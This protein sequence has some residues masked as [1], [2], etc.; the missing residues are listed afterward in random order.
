MRKTL[1]GALLIAVFAAAANTTEQ[2]EITSDRFEADEG[3][4]ISKFI[5]H[6]H[7]VKGPDELNASK[8]IVY[9]DAKRNPKRYEAI[10]NASFIVHMQKNDEYYTG[11]ADKLVYKPVKQIYEFY[12]H[13]VL[14]QPKLDRTVKGDEVIVDRLTGKSTVKGNKHKPVKFIFQVEEKRGKNR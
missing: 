14:R 11:K 7:M 4:M 3:K 2:V 12:G 10:G 1:Y 6:V 5:G 8:V 9:F 13:V